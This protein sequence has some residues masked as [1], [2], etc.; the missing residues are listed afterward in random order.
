MANA[1]GGYILI[2]V[3]EEK[4]VAQDFFTVNDAANVAQSINAICLQYIDPRIPNLEVE[5]Y[6]IKWQ[7]TDIETGNYSY[8]TE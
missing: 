8:P 1:E 3:R 4:K 5:R 6:P 2:G 7:N